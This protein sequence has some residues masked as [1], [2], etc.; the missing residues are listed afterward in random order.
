MDE[1][2][3]YFL[4]LEDRLTR[5]NILSA[6]PN[7]EF[8]VSLKDENDRSAVP[9]IGHAKLSEDGTSLVV[10]FGGQKSHDWPWNDLKEK[11]LNL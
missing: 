10:F 3:H 1:L 5:A 2:K 4:N 8:R 11:L 9:V 7:K 6:K